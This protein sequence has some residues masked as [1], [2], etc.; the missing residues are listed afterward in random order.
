M[1]PPANK[2][3]IADGWALAVELTGQWLRDSVRADWLLERHGGVMSGVERARCQEL[4]LGAIRHHLRLA[5]AL[6]P[7]LRRPPRPKLLAILH[8]AMAEMVGNPAVAPALIVDHAV[9]RT[10][11]MCSKAE[12]GLVN[13]VLRKL[14][15]ALR[16]APPDPATAS[17]EALAIHYSHPQ[18]LI[19]RWLGNH[20]R[21][22]TVHLLQ[23]NQTP[24]DVY[25]R[26]AEGI[27]PPACLETTAWPDFHRLKPGNWPEILGLI[28]R[29]FAYIQDPATRLASALLNPAQGT[30][31][32]DLCAAPGGKSLQLAQIVGS[33][34]CIVSV[35]RPGPR[36]R[37]MEENFSRYELANPAGARIEIVASD[38]LAL[39]PGTLAGRSL[40]TAFQSVLI[41]APCSNTGV[42]RHR[43]DARWR[44]E[45][46]EPARQA[47]VQLGLL[48][49]AARFVAPGGNLVYS[50]CSLE[51]EENS[52]V[53]A[54]FLEAGA[55][56]FEL[57]KSVESRP[58]DTGHDGAGAFQLR[59]INAG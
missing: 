36:I 27:T 20:G 24:A 9:S 32:L 43:V 33:G 17:P 56:S 2:A 23:L 18:W 16:T 50:T 29:G 55:G 28:E 34:G 3:Q 48:E 15:P 35:D 26:L 1:S 58:W 7:V 22:N 31:V 47:A 54:A 38:V 10:R 19:E 25:V 40:P 12:A 57:V 30:A 41:D 49:A 11:S 6:E 51:P 44:L 8:V 4:F 46:G 37:R 42:L 45:E 13:A 59:R 5:K 52:G 14:A 39:T 21:E 53:V